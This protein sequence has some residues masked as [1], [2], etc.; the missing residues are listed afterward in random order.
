VIMEYVS[1]ETMLS[2]KGNKLVHGSKFNFQSYVIIKKIN[3]R[4][5]YWRVAL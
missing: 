5:T 3:V 1:Y 2:E 4:I